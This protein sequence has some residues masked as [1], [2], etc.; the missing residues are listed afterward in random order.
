MAGA[1][2]GPNSLRANPRA[3]EAT[4]SLL[5]T[6]VEFQRA[7][8]E[9]VRRG[10]ESR[11]FDFRHR[12]AICFFASEGQCLAV[13]GAWTLAPKVGGRRGRR[14]GGGS[15]TPG[16]AGARKRLRR[17]AA[18]RRQ[19]VCERCTGGV[20]SDTHR[21]AAMLRASYA[22]RAFIAAPASATP[23]RDA[24]CISIRDDGARCPA[25][26]VREIPRVHRRSLSLSW[27]AGATTGRRG[28]SQPP[29]RGVNHRLHSI[30]AACSGIE[31]IR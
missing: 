19:K 29:L 18:R 11:L 2:T 13:R 14:R 8:T 6:H 26:S 28:R 30:L 7:I 3:G 1:K 27:A 24:R 25:E 17:R 22:S 4:A 10:A 31:P 20:C 12:Q 15:T 16:E 9:H 23:V 21:L 5:R